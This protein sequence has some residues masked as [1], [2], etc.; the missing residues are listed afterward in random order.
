MILDRRKKQERYTQ[1]S[2]KDFGT[3]MKIDFQEYYPSLNLLLVYPVT[4]ELM[5]L[6]CQFDM[7]GFVF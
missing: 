7:E 6:T 4:F 2:P 3:S 1:N 5:K